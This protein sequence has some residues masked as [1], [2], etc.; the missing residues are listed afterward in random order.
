MD[1]LEGV[2]VRVALV[3]CSFPLMDREASPWGLRR[4]T[5]PKSSTSLEYT[6]LARLKEGHPLI[7]EG[8]FIKQTLKLSKQLL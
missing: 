6:E 7:K 4:K 1:A 5:L 8:G 3:F 2:S